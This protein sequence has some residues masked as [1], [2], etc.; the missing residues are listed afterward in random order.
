MHLV[1]EQL[2]GTS[3]DPSAKVVFTAHLTTLGGGDK[4]EGVLSL[5]LYLL[6][7]RF[8]VSNLLSSFDLNF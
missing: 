6:V 3:H 4:L 7:L 1:A 5:A 8:L 2:C